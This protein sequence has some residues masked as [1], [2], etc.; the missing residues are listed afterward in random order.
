[1]IGGKITGLGPIRIFDTESGDLLLEGQLTGY[2]FKDP[3]VPGR[4][5]HVKATVPK[6]CPHCGAELNNQTD[7]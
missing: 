2:V 5:W 6:K 3:K 4:Y 1:M 7:K